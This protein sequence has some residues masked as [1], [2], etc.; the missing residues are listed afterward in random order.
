MR[1]ED[2]KSIVTGAASGLG[3]C[4][5]LELCR[6]GASVVAVDVNRAGLDRLAA[7]AAGSPG[8]LLNR[9]GDVT[10]EGAVK[11]FVREASEWMDGVNVVVNNAGVLLDGLLVKEEGGWVRRLPLAQLRKVLDV[12]LVGPF[13]VAREGAA[14]MLERGVTD[15]VIVNLS[16]L[17]RVGNAGQAAYAASKAG[18]DA[19]TRTWA[20][21]LAPHGIRVAGIAPGVIQTPI[22]DNI[23]DE[24]RDSL[25]AGIPLGRFGDPGE[26]WLTLKYVLECG[27]LTGRVIEI[28]GGA[29]M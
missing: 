26:V 21:E 27:F 13:L 9:V 20:V 24:A 17:A 7:D 14:D 10:D 12:N 25:L 28:D 29:H 15:G 5:A 23:S 11:A 19:A 1:L 16:S 2:V 4:F 3:Y 8:R 6:A 18:L 22:L